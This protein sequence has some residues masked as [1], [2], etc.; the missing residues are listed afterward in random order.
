MAYPDVYGK[1]ILAYFQVIVKLSFWH[2]A[3]RIY[4]MKGIRLMEILKS[5]SPAKIPETEQ[6]ELIS[7]IVA[8]YNIEGYVEKSVKSILEQSY[9]NLEIILVDDGSTDESGRICDKL[10]KL[11][12]RI[13]V[14]HKPNGGPA[15]ARNAGIAIAKG[16]FIGFVDGDDW[17][18]T[19]MYEKMLGAMLEQHADMAI[20]RYRRVYKDHTEDASLD[21][22]VLFEERE[23][24]Q[25]YVEER[26]EYDIQNAAW[27][28]LYRKE[29]LQNLSFP[30]GKWYEDIMFA[31]VALSNAER[32]VY[33]DTAY[34]NYIID[35]EG[36]I[37]NTR[38]NPR[39]FTDQIPAYREKTIFLQSLG[40]QDLAD[41]HDYFFYKRLLLFYN[42]LTRDTIPD[43]KRYLQDIT[44]IINGCIGDDK[45][46]YERVYRCNI[47]NP[48]EK[49]KM[50]LFLKSPLLYR[51]FMAVNETVILPLK[52][53]LRK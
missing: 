16:N 31:T 47:A 11:D 43:K 41:T 12:G 19:D 6:K 21:R 30:T 10:A 3:L 45:E 42:Q 20:C 37:M 33:L 24:L 34:Y 15:D 35:R 36:S 38:I 39:T 18:D 26:E 23:A 44:S 13:R 8:I 5:Y 27:N 25:V 40:R 51:I 9:R 50:D 32:C 2:N 17:I 22:A 46:Y 29:I 4:K 52:L 1:R 53:K 14:I 28:K 48:N 7:V 49:T